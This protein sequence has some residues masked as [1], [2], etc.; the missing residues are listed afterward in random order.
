MDS[1]Y[2]LRNQKASARKSFATEESKVR[3]VK[4]N[5][6]QL[7]QSLMQIFEVQRDPLNRM[8]IKF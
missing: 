7:Q 1:V 8:K 4:Q 5:V 2:Q 6:R 3:F